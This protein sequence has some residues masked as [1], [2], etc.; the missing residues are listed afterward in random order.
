[1]CPP[2]TPVVPAAE[3]RGK[4]GGRDVVRNDPLYA[5]WVYQG[6]A[7]LGRIMEALDALGL[8]ADTLIIVTSDNGAEGLPFAPWR[9]AKRSIHDQLHLKTHTAPPTFP[10]LRMFLRG[11]S[12]SISPTLA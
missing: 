10:R 2:H 8:A 1:M 3:F 4:S 6:D 9:D 11:R 12:T 7:M 5:D